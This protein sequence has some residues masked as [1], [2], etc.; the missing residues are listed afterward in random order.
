MSRFRL[1]FEKIKDK[2]DWY[3]NPIT[4][5]VAIINAF[6]S[7]RSLAIPPTSATIA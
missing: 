7:A 4:V 3:A 2:Y 1:G 6:D 5:G